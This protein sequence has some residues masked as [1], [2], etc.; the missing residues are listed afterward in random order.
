M[1][2]KFAIITIAIVLLCSIIACSNLETWNIG[3]FL[4]SIQ[5]M[6]DNS[7]TPG[8][9]NVTGNIMAVFY[10]RADERALFACTNA[11]I[12]DVGDGTWNVTSQQIVAVG[13]KQSLVTYGLYKYKALTIGPAS[14]PYMADLGLEAITWEDLPKSMHVAALKSV[15][16]VSGSPRATVI[17]KYLGI[18]YEIPNCRVSQVA[19]DNY[20][21][22]KITVFNPAYGIDAPE[23]KNCFVLVYFI[24]ETPYGTE[25]MIPVLVDKVIK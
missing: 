9:A 6:A 20:V 25:V 4:G 5:V 21:A 24:S 14:P 8:S 19:Y 18:N 12:I 22:G 13:I 17:R 15:A 23:N 16:M 11:Q 2:R 3:S 10:T 1:K 7:T